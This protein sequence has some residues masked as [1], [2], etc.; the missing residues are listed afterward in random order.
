MQRN[1]LQAS[2]LALLTDYVVQGKP[3]IDIDFVTG[4]LCH[5]V[6]IVQLFFRY[7]LVRRLNI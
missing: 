3:K 7:N 2:L 6:S 1:I 5:I 4:K